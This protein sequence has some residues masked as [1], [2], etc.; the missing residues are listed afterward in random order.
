MIDD[1]RKLRNQVE[2]KKAAIMADF[3]NTKSRGNLISSE[4]SAS[5]P[6]RPQSAY[7]GAKKRK[8]TKTH[9]RAK[10]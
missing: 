4:M 2:A 9:V 10:S 5:Q 6:I 7:Y 3:E 1:R 8:R